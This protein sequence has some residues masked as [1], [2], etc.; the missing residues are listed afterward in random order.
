MSTS[1]NVTVVLVAFVVVGLLVV[2]V[3]PQGIM[4]V[5][6][7]TLRRWTGRDR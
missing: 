6:A 3:R 1:E 2:L 7:A 5:W 4:L